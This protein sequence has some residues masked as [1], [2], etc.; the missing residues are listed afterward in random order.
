MALGY[1]THHPAAGRADMSTCRA[2]ARICRAE[3]LREV[4][5]YPL[6]AESFGRATLRAR[7]S[8][9]GLNA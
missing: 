7:Y 6:K 3:R 9:W 2:A 5:A 1:R 8:G 4:L